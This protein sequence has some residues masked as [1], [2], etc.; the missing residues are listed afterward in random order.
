[1]LTVLDWKSFM[2][3]FYL[4]RF[5]KVAPLCTD[6]CCRKKGDKFIAVLEEGV[7]MACTIDKH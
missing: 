2:N 6:K 7:F 5:P 4:S 3:W 1:M